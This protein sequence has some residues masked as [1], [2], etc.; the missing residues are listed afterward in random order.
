MHE[1]QTA[2]K[3][4]VGEK[5]AELVEDGMIVGLGTGSTAYWFIKKLAERVAGGLRITG[6]AT[7]VRTAELAESL[8]IR[9]VDVNEVGEV[10][11]TV[12]GADEIDDHFNAIKGGGGALLREKIVASISRRMVVIVD[13]TKR[14]ERL[15]RFPLPVEMVPF[16]YKHTLRK[17]EQA[18]CAPRLREKDGAPFVTDG[19]HY[20]VDLHLG[21]IDDPERLAGSIGNMPGVVEHGLF[22]GLVTDVLIAEDGEVRMMK[23]A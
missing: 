14:V 6:V 16:G 19:G 8:G 1:Q 12:D 18:G 15:G 13:S 17:L 5:A 23:R 9:V 3:R 7:S 20:I 2:E 10:D 21:R 11:L 22:I 4:R